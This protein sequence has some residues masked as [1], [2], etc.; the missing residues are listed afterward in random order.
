MGLDLYFY[1]CKKSCY[2]Q[3]KD[4]PKALS[5]EAQSAVSRWMYKEL[6]HPEHFEAAPGIVDGCRCPEES[7]NLILV[8]GWLEHVGSAYRWFLEHTVLTMNDA[9]PVKVNTQ[10][11]FALCKACEAVLRLE[12]NE[13]GEIDSDICERHLPIAV[14]PYF[15]IDEYTE[16]YQ[17]EV[18]AV[19]D[20]IT[21]L[22][23]TIDFENEVILVQANW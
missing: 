22:L 21:A 15:G 9:H 18:E 10:D 13:Y 17:E 16:D 2:E 23:N 4:N 3:H 6:G 11:I 1:R 5:S 12:P 20:T 8:D 7:D 19:L 14:D